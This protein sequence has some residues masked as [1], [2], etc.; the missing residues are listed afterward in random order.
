MEA[1]KR[2][3]L[4]K[5]DGI[6]VEI[7][8]E[9]DDGIVYYDIEMKTN[10]G[11]VEMEIHAFTGEILSFSKDSTSSKG[12][13]NLNINTSALIGIAEAERIALQHFSGTIIEIELDS[14]NGR[15]YYEVEMK[16]SKGEVELEI[17]AYTGK[18]ISIEIDD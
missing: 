9:S 8:L 15:L 11:E 17:D 12:L 6:I 3:A 5:V 16:T 7:E 18:I 10:S 2:I 14:D 1:A 4:S 13:L